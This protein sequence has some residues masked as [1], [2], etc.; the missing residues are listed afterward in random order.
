MQEYIILENVLEDL[1][2]NDLEFAIIEISEI[3]GGIYD[4]IK[5]LISFGEYEKAKKLI[6]KTMA[7]YEKNLL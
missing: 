1:E 3:E 2:N 6:I 5:T 4:N 7:D